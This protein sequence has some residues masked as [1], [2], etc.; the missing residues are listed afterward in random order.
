LLLVGVAVT[1]VFIWLR[2]WLKNKDAE[3]S[4]DT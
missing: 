2:R 3:S 1:L 4:I